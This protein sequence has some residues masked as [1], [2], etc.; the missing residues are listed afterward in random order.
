MSFERNRVLR[1]AYWIAI[2]ALFAGA[3][4]KR[5]SLP[6]DPI[7]DPDTWG[8]LSPAL[9]QLTGEG[10]SHESRNFLYPGF[11]WALLRFFGD[12]R[13]ITVAQ[14]VLGLSAGGLLLLAWRRSRL[15]VPASRL[16]SAA[17]E[18]L[19]LILAA[20]CL[21]AG[22]PI[23]A[24]T[25]IRPEGVCA[26]FLALNLW[27]VVEFAVRG[28]VIREKAVTIVGIGTVFTAIV[29][30]SL[31]PSFVFLAAVSLVPVGLFL[32]GRNRRQSKIGIGLG[33]MAAAVVLF[34]PEYFLSRKDEL[35]RLFLPTS[36]F[37]I[38]AD[39]IRDQ[40]AD[41]LQRGVDLP[42]PRD[43][44][45]RVHQ[46]L[47][48]EIAKSQEAEPERYRSLGFSGDYLM[49]NETSFA[50]RLLEESNYDFGRVTAFYRF[51]YWRTWQ[52]R[53]REMLR[54]VWRQ[55]AL[56]YQP[57]CPAYDRE[58]IIELNSW[59]EL[60]V[61][62]LD[63]DPY[64]E[65]W[66]RYS[67]AVD[68]MRRAELLSHSAPFI[69]Q[70]KVVRRTVVFFAVMYLALLGTTVTLG[71]LT[72]VW[73]SLRQRLGWLVALTL[74]VFAYNVAACLEVAII[75][76]LEVPRYSTVQFVFT[77]FAEFLGL[78]L[79]LESILPAIRWGRP[80]H[81]SAPGE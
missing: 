28:F 38:H 19:G 61:S 63:R 42:Y 31:K 53:P 24:E 44:L 17:H 21:F 55:F 78:W 45:G 27:L 7:A 79:L 70:S 47:A 30:G 25:Q 39:L 72:L 3:A 50:A 67:P 1:A 20:A 2:G 52:H 66:K 26:F 62:S 58:K 32:L 37:T 60:T 40:I 22:E 77:L 56:F 6:L 33:G 65:T 10:F 51:Y 64:R 74:F 48:S 69:E 15:F 68:F 76:S 18:T 80:I 11:L 12:F 35:A 8:Y 73:R 23:R 29:L 14:H 4:W 71:L 54:K 46:Q 16:P 49:Y 81:T 75:N 41:D 57:V 36:L 34:V 9:H 5:F 59:Y 43:W 13:A